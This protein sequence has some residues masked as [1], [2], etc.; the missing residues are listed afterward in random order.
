MTRN[1]KIIAAVV[2]VVVLAAGGIAYAV[3]SGSSKSSAGEVVVFSRV[4]ERTLQ[5]TVALSGTLARKQIRNITAS[6]EGLVSA[7][8]ATNDS[9]ATQGQVLFSLGGRDAITEP[10]ALPFFRSLAPGDQG[11]DVLEL[12]QILA[13]AGDDPGTMDNY[14]SQ[15]TQ[16]ALAQWQAQHHYPNATP[17]NPESVTVSLQQ[18]T[19]YKVGTQSAA[20]LIIGPP[21]AQT[22]SAVSG[23]GSTKAT[24]DAY[25]PFL[26]HVSPGITI[27]SVDNQV[28][29]GQPATFVVSAD[30]A[31]TSA[32]TINLTAGG[33]AGSNDI[34]TP[35][36]TATIAAGATQT[37]FQVQTR[38]NNVVEAEPTIIMSVAAGTGYAVGSPSSAQTTITNTNVPALTI[39][40]GTTVSPG[41]TATL[42]V[43]ANQA[44]AQ[45]TQVQLSVSGSASAG[46][47]YNPV[48]PIV[49]L[50]A[51]QTTASVTVS[52]L[53]SN[54]IAPNKFIVV[55][56][57]PSPAN[58]TVG[59]PGSAVVQISGSSAQPTATL[60]SATTYLDQ[61]E[62]YDVAVGLSQAVST[63]TTIALS[64]GGSA[65]QGT[66]YTP[67]AGSIVVPAGQTSVTVQIPT[68]TSNV[69]EPNKILTVSLAPSSSYLVG[70]PSS[71]TVTIT[72]QV[73]PTLTITS[74]TT[75]LAQGGAASFTISADQA[76]VK[77]ISV[78]FSAQGTAE[79][80]QNYVPLAGTAVLKAGQTSVTVVLQSIQSNI[81]FEPTDMIVGSWPTHVGQVFV[82]AGASVAPGEAILSL[83]EPDLSVTLQATA[84]QRS[85]LAV[86]QKCTI[87]I[88]GG[89]TSGTG[90][91][92]ELDTAPTT[93]TGSGGQSSQVYEGR[94]AV[95]DLTGADGSAVSITVVNQQVDNALTVPISA[96]KQNGSGVNVVRVI[97]LDQGGRVTEVPV[98]TGLTEG[99][100][101]QIKSGLHLNQLVISG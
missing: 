16:F 40:G 57:A 67:P 98:R 90:V 43:S 92:T 72:S 46:T 82:K 83:T 1:R 49:T 20:G 62:P 79:P 53:A 74:N 69:V 75:T 59:S 41:G 19:G 68:V 101:I 28:P 33:T 2:A 21:A 86:G 23:G 31:P 34:V 55:S 71:A 100:Y 63:P 18:G 89:N 6:T 65:V 26:P 39:T 84:A 17:A 97:N 54:V 87:Q 50:A 81:T 14:F 7:V 25:R 96:V 80:G 66:D 51:G 15:Q 11:V 5:N 85:E 91:I 10:G 13:S 4:Q 29:Q 56:L 52:T 30:S 27:Q 45:A 99:S 38:S 24:L 35:P 8:A 9:T 77:N 3:S 95:S 73:L 48:N 76:P 61:G 78:N 88:S 44:P 47:D 32:L 58:Y 12:K 93:V 70:S 60:T 37:T 94:I 22:T 36:T 42:T 64:Y